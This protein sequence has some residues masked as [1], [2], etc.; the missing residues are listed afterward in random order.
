MQQGWDSLSALVKD[1]FTGKVRQESLWTMI[2]TANIMICSESRE[3]VY[4]GERRNESQVVQ[5]GDTVREARM[6]WF[7]RVQRR[8]SGYV[9]DGLYKGWTGGAL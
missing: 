7:G 4:D 8:G 5:G 3:Q 9:V 2:F 6:R 1:R